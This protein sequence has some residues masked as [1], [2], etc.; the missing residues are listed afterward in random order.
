MSVTDNQRR[1]IQRAVRSLL[2]KKKEKVQAEH[3]LEMDMIKESARAKFDSIYHFSEWETEEKSIERIIHDAQVR[4]ANHRGA[5]LKDMFPGHEFST[6]HSDFS[7]EA[8][9]YFNG[10][11]DEEYQKVLSQADFFSDLKQCDDIWNEADVM[12]TLATNSAGISR[13][14]SR[15][16]ELL[17]LEV[18]A[19]LKMAA[20]E[21]L[22]N[23]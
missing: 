12:I 23:L 5:V 7:D 10:L 4:L 20:G 17:S 3:R 21:G 6:Y 22:R 18:S 19:V 13:V 1:D 16:A 14:Y 11:V 8:T 15:L 9:R 2:G